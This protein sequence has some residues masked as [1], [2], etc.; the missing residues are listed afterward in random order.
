MGFK[1][2]RKRDVVVMKVQIVPADK[3]AFEEIVKLAVAESRWDVNICDH[4]IWC[5]A[6]TPDCCLAA[7]NIGKQVIL[8]SLPGP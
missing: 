2:S 8:K 7:F 4:D 5:K 6:F 1:P 3:T